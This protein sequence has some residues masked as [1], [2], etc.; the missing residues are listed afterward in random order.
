MIIKNKQKKAM[1]HVE[2]ILSFALFLGF[3]IFIFVIFKPFK[4]G[5][6]TDVYADSIS[7]EIKKSSQIEVVSLS[8]SFN[9]NPSNWVSVPIKLNKLVVKD[10]TGNIINSAKDSDNVYIEG[11]GTFNFIYITAS[12]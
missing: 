10:N 7:Y 3:L 6:S 1:T 4:I 8:L 9:S 2:V 12:P 5:D 11:D